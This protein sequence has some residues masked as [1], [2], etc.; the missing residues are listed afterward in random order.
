MRNDLYKFDIL[1]NIW[2]KV[3]SKGT[4]P[5]ARSGMKSVSVDDLSKIYFFGGYVNKD[6][7]HYND[8][9]F[10]DIVDESW[11]LVK[12]TAETPQENSNE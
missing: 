11:T 10:F 4:P 8:L 5:S 3:N 9:Y 7:Y 6:S 12:E 1:N 2:T